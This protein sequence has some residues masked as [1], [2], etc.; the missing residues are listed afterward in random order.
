M[1]CCLALRTALA[2]DG[3]TDAVS[4]AVHSARM[5]K[6]VRCCSAAR[7]AGVNPFAG[8]SGPG[9][10]PAA[11]GENNE[12]AR[13]A[14]APAAAA[15]RAEGEGEDEGTQSSLRLR[16]EAG[17]ALVAPTGGD[18][19]NTGASG[20]M[21]YPLPPF[22]PPLP[23]GL[24]ALPGGGT[25]PADKGICHCGAG[26][27]EGTSGRKLILLALCPL[28]RLALA[29]AGRVRVGAGLI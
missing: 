4:T 13:P 26:E 19:A 8:L 1:S 25:R 10:I 9:P 14:F 18:G 3:S 17:T 23:L 22:R 6:W 21:L 29:P 12:C 16:P 5:R 28:A 7:L 24:P 11:R 20:Y 15:E 2:E 27:A